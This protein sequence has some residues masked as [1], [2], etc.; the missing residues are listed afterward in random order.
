MAGNPDRTP[1]KGGETKL[2]VLRQSVRKHLTDHP[3]TEIAI[4]LE[5]QEVEYVLGGHARCRREAGQALDR[6][7]DPAQ[8]QGGVENRL[9][10]VHPLGDLPEQIGFTAL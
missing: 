4:G 8:P 7:T 9:D 1:V 10:A 3:S 6:R 5:H 2:E